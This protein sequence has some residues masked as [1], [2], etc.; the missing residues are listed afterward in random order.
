MKFIF[1]ILALLF[2]SCKEQ[3]ENG[4]SASATIVYS[5]MLAADG[6]EWVVRIDSI[7]YHPEAL[8]SIYMK[9]S[10]R[11]KICYEE[12]N[13]RFSCG[14]IPGGIPVIRLIDIKK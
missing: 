13:D 12:T 8:D 14:L 5:G 9:D 10:L 6:C 7:S 2:F 4:M 3:C 1:L 11:L